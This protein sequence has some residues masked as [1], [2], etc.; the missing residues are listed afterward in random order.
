MTKM[1]LSLNI[2]LMTERS[3]VLSD[4]MDVKCLL[5]VLV[6]IEVA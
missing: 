4:P 2:I 6:Q 5:R 1:V 3:V